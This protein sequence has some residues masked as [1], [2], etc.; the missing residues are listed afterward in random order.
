MSSSPRKILL[1]AAEKSGAMSVGIPRISAS[2]RSVELNPNLALLEVV[3]PNISVASPNLT[4]SL[5][6]PAT[7]II[8]SRTFAAPPPSALSWCADPSILILIPQLFSMIVAAGSLLLVYLARFTVEMVSVVVVVFP[9]NLWWENARLT[10]RPSS[11][12]LHLPLA[13]R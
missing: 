12:W 10:F 7:H 5:A 8:G 3:V 9:K 13:A 4:I 11:V 1:L 2:G 6:R